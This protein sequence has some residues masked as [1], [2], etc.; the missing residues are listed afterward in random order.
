MHDARSHS[1]ADEVHAPEDVERPGGIGAVDMFTFDEKPASFDTLR[2]TGCVLV[3][4]SR[5]KQ[6]QGVGD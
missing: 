1:P 4:P 6:N 3:D 5:M 2:L